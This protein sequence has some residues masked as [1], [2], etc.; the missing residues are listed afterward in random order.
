MIEKYIENYI[1]WNHPIKNNSEFLDL[2][3]I[4]QLKE[5]R[6]NVYDF[7]GDEISIVKIDVDDLIGFG[8]Q[9]GS[10]VPKPM[11][12]IYRKLLCR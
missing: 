1:S 11:M 9:C 2:L 6:P 3:Q 10:S 12:L 5:I 4:D 7:Y 8:T